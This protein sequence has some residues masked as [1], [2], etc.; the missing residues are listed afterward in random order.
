MCFFVSNP[1]SLN[2]DGRVEESRFDDPKHT[3][4]V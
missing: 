3:E 4:H 1:R 2:F